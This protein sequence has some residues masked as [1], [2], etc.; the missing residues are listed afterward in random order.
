SDAFT[1]VVCVTSLFSH[2]QSTAATYPL[3]LHDAL[4]IWYWRPRARIAR[5][6][7]LEL[8]EKFLHRSQPLAGAALGAALP[9]LPAS[10]VWSCF[11]LTFMLNSE[12]RLLL[13]FTALISTRSGFSR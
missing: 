5:I 8:F 2:P 10:S 12:T 13:T 6:E 1:R 7:I 11:R 4:P 9:D 3:S